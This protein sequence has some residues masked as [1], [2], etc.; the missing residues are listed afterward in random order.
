MRLQPGVSRVQVLTQIFFFFPHV[1]VEQALPLS[2]N[3]PM[4][5]THLGKNPTWST[6][7]DLWMYTQLTIHIEFLIALKVVVADYRAVLDLRSLPW[8]ERWWLVVHGSWVSMTD[9]CMTV[10]MDIGI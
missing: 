3:K 9:A 2:L 1:I 4:Q 10:G 8:L 6:M 7:R 5:W